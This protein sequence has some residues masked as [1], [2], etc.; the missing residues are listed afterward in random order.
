MK[1]YVLTEQD[2][3]D[4]VAFRKRCVE[5][6]KLPQVPV[7]ANQN[8]PIGID[9]WG[10]L[11]PVDDEDRRKQAQAARRARHRRSARARDRRCPRHDHGGPPAGGFAALPGARDGAAA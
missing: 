2:K 8:F 1:K 9:P 6:N 11:F 7:P 3:I 10:N 4:N 5:R